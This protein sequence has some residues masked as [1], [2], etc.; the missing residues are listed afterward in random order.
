MFSD[1]VRAVIGLPAV[2]YFVLTMEENWLKNSKVSDTLWV[3][4]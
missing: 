1:N 4:V 3:A 2:G